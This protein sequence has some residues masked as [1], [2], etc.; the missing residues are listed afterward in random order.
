VS[1][2]SMNWIETAKA[3]FRAEKPE[4]FTNYRHCDECQEHDETLRGTAI[5]TI[6]LAELGSPSWDPLC[7]CSAEGKKYFM[8]ALVR[9]SLETVDDAFY[10]SQFLFHLEADGVDHALV[11]SCT[12]E[13]RAFIAAFLRHMMENHAGTIDRQRCSDDVLRTYEIWA[14]DSDATV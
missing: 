4:H 11:K 6:G 7:F 3:L 13:Q 14:D 5:D 12:G 9:L 1:S 8:P 2:D 10:F